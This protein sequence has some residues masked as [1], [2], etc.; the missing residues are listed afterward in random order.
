MRCEDEVF[1]SLNGVPDSHE[2][3]AAAT[4]NTSSIRAKADTKHLTGPGV[5]NAQHLAAVGI[6]NAHRAVGA[7][8][9]DPCSIPAEADTVDGGSMTDKGFPLFPRFSTDDLDR[10]I[11]SPPHT[12]GRYWMAN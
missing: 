12:W 9:C 2:V 6:P 4:D 3:I 5:E 11:G 10:P 8:A 1:L 7:S